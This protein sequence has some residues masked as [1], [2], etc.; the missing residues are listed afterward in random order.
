MYLSKLNEL[1]KELA[2]LKIP[3][4]IPALNTDIHHLLAPPHE[5][6]ETGLLP[7]RL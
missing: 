6:P 5:Y 2:R 3:S 7:R 1:G 4:R